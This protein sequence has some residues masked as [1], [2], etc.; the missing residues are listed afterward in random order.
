MA[1]SSKG[2]ARIGQSLSCRLSTSRG[3]LHFQARNR[4]TLSQSRSEGL[5]RASGGVSR[6]GPVH[7]AGRNSPGRGTVLKGTSETFDEPAE[8]RTGG[9]VQSAK[10]RRTGA[11]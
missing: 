5:A 1:F 6:D 10:G 8:T 11:G 4:E 7:G 3:A 2:P 9:E